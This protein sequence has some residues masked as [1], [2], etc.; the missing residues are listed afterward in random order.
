LSE[1]SQVSHNGL[2]A[3]LVN[4]RAITNLRVEVFG[5]QV[6]GGLTSA[7]LASLSTS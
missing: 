7:R 3:L 6:S 4:L 5:A 2:R 1:V